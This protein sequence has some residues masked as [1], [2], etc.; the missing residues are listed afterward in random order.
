VVRVDLFQ[1]WQTLEDGE[2]NLTGALE[3]A[4]EADEAL[5]IG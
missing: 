3:I 5:H 2:Q 4:G 1:A